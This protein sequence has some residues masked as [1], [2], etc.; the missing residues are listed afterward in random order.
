MPARAA[1]SR[2]ATTRACSSPSTRATSLR[3]DRLVLDIAD[4]G[5]HA[6]EWHAALPG[7]VQRDLLGAGVEFGVLRREQQAG[8][9]DH[10]RVPS[11][12]CGKDAGRAEQKHQDL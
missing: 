4:H 11:M 10:R 3:R 9:R 12:P 8:V 1:S 7:E 5:Y 6:G 2:S